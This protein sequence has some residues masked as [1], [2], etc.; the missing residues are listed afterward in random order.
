MYDEVYSGRDRWMSSPRSVT[1][2]RPKSVREVY[3]PAVQDLSDQAARNGSGTPEESILSVV[4]TCTPRGS[5]S[6]VVHYA[7]KFHSPTPLI[8]QFN[9]EEAIKSSPTAQLSFNKHHDEYHEELHRQ[10]VLVSAH[11][12]RK[13]HTRMRRAKSV[14]ANVNRANGT[15]QRRNS[16]M[17]KEEENGRLELIVT[18]RSPIEEKD[19]KER[20]NYRLTS[21]TK[22]KTSHGNLMANGTPQTVVNGYTQ[23]LI[24]HYP[25]YSEKYSNWLTSGFKVQSFRTH[26]SDFYTHSRPPPPLLQY[27]NRPKTVNTRRGVKK[28]HGSVDFNIIGVQRK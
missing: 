9:P 7:D 28:V 11:H 6:N 5:R 13:L 23:T 15:D 19:L 26:P 1:P 22:P 12:R 8:S 4:S 10:R 27:I 17:D 16:M 3:H 2:G 25:K 18:N 24:Q 21:R 14:P 20:V